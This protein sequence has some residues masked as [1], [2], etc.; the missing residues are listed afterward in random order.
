MRLMKK[1]SKGLR[2]FANRGFRGRHV[3]IL[4][5]D[6]KLNLDL[7]WKHEFDYLDFAEN[8]RI[9]GA[10][11][12]DV[13][14]FGTL[15]KPGQTV[16]DA[17]ANIG[18]TA[19]LAE[20]AGAAEVH[21]FEPD[22]RLAERLEQNGSSGKTTLHRKAL[23]EARGQLD[24]YLSEKHNQGSTSNRMMIDKFPQ[25][26]GKAEKIQVEV[27]TVD[28]VFPGKHF[29]FFKVDVE[30]AELAVLRGSIKHFESDPPS[31]V[32]IE[33]FEEFRAEVFNFLKPF[34]KHGY[35]IGCDAS[36]AGRLFPIDQPLTLD[37]ENVYLNPP[38][39]VFSL[40]DLEPLTRSWT[41]PPLMR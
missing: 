38:S 39:F 35:Q 1:V 9:N 28:E 23:G 24:L 31:I 33:V 29:D 14:A 41:K 13:W 2:W 6:K 27:T 17:G 26:F 22:P 7:R 11:G 8:R 30:G 5:A 12:L 15:V 3:S 20:I 18:F 40:E 34:Y 16:L 4:L 37:R 21:C 10:I 36:G 32:Y 19:L 25:V